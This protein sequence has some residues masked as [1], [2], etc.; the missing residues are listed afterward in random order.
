M[1]IGDLSRR[2][3]VSVRMLRY[4]EA[5]GLLQPGRTDS[6]YRDYGADAL[7]TV[8]QIKG[9]GAAGMTLATIRQFLPCTLAQRGAF[10]PCDELKAALRQQIDL[11]D[12]RMAQLADSRDILSG[13]L[14]Q[15]E[16]QTPA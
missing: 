11:V 5:Q 3:G 7:A 12:Q 15:M 1:K 16:R 8:R 10:E 2:T 6:G 4:Y 9:L 13:L 14:A